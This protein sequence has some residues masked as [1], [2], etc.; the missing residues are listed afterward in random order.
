MDFSLTDRKELTMKEK[1]PR[2]PFSTPL[3]PRIYDGLDYGE[4][5]T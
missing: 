5:Q 2:T 1:M 3:R 4:I